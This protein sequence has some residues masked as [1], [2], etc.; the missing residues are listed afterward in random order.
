MPVTTGQNEGICVCGVI[1]RKVLQG[2]REDKDYAA[3][4][5]CFK[6]FINWRCDA[7][8]DGIAMRARYTLVPSERHLLLHRHP[9]KDHSAGVCRLSSTTACAV[10]EYRAGDAERRLMK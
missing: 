7:P 10:T 6:A 1:L 4:S 8:F 9:W 5:V 3:V 2:I